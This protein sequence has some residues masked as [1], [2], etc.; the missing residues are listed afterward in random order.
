M[1]SVQLDHL[2]EVVSARRQ[3]FNDYKEALIGVAEVEWQPEL[4][5]NYSNRWLTALIFDHVH[6]LDV[7]KKF[8]QHNI[9][10]KRLWK[11][12]HIQ[13]SFSGTKFFGNGTCVELWEKGI[14]L[15]SGKLPDEEDLG[16]VVEILMKILNR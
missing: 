2:Q 8:E 1:G 11:P 13:K 14:C 15:P 6:P 12:L 10:V 7:I 4:E 9:E 5:G 3:R 16:R